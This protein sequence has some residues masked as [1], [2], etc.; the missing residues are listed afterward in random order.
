LGNLVIKKVEYKGDKYSFESPELSEGLN[1]IVGDNGSGK[2]TFTYF[3][4]FG[5]GIKVK[6]FNES[7]D[8]KYLEIINDTNN[9]VK[10]SVSING[11]EY[12]LKRFLGENEIIVKEG[13]EV[14][15]YPTNRQVASYIFSDWMLEKIGITPFQLELG[16]ST[17]YFNFSDLFRLLNYDQKTELGKI[18]KSPEDENPFKNS[19]IIRRTIFESLLGS[20][21]NAL[22]LKK[23]ELNQA[24]IDA[25]IAKGSVD[26]YISDNQ[27]LANNDA[28]SAKIL[29]G[30]SNKTEVLNELKNKRKV[31]QKE[32]IVAVDPKIKDIDVRKTKIIEGELKLSDV[33]LD[34]SMLEKEIY[35]VQRIYNEQADEISQLNKIIYTSEKLDLFSLEICPF[36][37]NEPPKK[38]GHCI[39]GSE[40]KPHQYEKFVYL[41][42]EYK[43]ILESKTKAL[44]T[45]SDALNGYKDKL[46][47]LQEEKKG[48]E[49][50][51]IVLKQELTGY[52]EAID[53]SGNSDL[54]DDLNNQ[55]SIQNNSISELKN[56]VE[57]V[58]HI[59]KLNID[60]KEKDDKVTRIKGEHT[61]LERS[62]KG[63]IT[64]KIKSFNEI[65]KTL[66]LDSSLDCSI[67]EING[68]YMPLID[69]G[70][71]KEASSKV[72]KRLMY[73]FSILALSL[74]E[75][76]IFAPK[77]LLI[78]TPQ[79]AGIDYKNL[80]DNLELLNTIL[81]EDKTAGY[82][83]IMTTGENMYPDSFASAI[84]L[85]LCK[86]EKN[87]I[88]KKRKV[89]KRRT[90]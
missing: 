86:K 56:V 15:R 3:I 16:S 4:E 12:G 21:S 14:N 69:D 22:Y 68:D 26:N 48:L 1:L 50:K 84:K 59:E 42:S 29:L 64:S 53:Y 7:T 52:I 55:I 46:S 61:S 57:K 35:N 81:P 74:S 45:I 47:L 30:I 90:K 2:S 72:P 66:M 70:A 31:L 23:N 43:E 49:E 18:Y 11:V 87:F 80:N 33:T 77:F 71:Y 19:M 41:S 82:Q 73:Y 36:C 34:S 5:L 20:N 13:S 89:A 8:E 40:I 25:K 83:V 65:Y 78:D 24:R 9:Y 38:S 32:S 10:L 63:D 44:E 39:C 76:Q 37:M 51:V 88:L 28:N 85:V 27:F 58:A 6:Y 60:L 67:A 75:H 17:F 54:I 79:S 62:F